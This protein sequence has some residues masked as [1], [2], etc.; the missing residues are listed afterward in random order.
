VAAGRDILTKYVRV[1]QKDKYP[2]R[3]KP[4]KEE[5]KPREPLEDG[6]YIYNGGFDVDDSAAVGVDGVPYTSYWTF[7]TASGGAATVNVEEGVM[8]VQIENGGTTDYGVQL[9]QAPIHLEKGAKY[10][11]SFDMKA[12]NP[13]QVKLK[14]GGDG[15]RDGLNRDDQL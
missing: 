15:D 13:R 9:L 4:A 8:H 12:E 14:I 11:A 5:V 6:N 10:K 7:L 2:H 1:Y 3:E